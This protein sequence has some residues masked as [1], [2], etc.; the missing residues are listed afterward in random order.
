MTF[1]QKLMLLAMLALAATI[2]AVPAAFAQTEPLAHNQNPQLIG[3]QEIHGA[4]DTAC[5][6]VSPT[7]AP[8][9]SPTVTSGGCRMH[10]TGTNVALSAHLSAGG[11]EIVVSTCNV[12]FDARLDA[13]AEGYLVHQEFT[14]GT[15]GSC[16]R[17]ACGQL[18]PPTSEG[19]AYSFFIREVEPEPSEQG[20]ALFCTETLDGQGATHCEVTAPVLAPVRHEAQLSVND[21]SGHGTSFPHCEISGVF[22]TEATLGTSGEGQ[23]EQR[24]EVRHS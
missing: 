9:V 13:A 20:T 4:P 15:S 14:Q 24:L 16:T 12:E 8:A 10:F 3:Q 22:N 21:V 18:T 2:A 19:R 23:L 17:R 5:P 6:A 1:V 7:P 11:A